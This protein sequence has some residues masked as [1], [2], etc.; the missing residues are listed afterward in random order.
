MS[1]PGMR[2]WGGSKHSTIHLIG[3]VSRAGTSHRDVYASDCYA[4][5]G[6]LMTH[7]CTSPLTLNEDMRPCTPALF[8][9]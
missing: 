9:E 7:A 8:S 3:N 1:V 4:S 2:G 5:D 6:V